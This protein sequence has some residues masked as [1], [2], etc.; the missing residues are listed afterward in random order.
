MT[1]HL[2]MLHVTV[3]DGERAFLTRDGKLER[4]LAPEAAPRAGDDGDA[5]CADPADGSFH[6]LAPTIRC[7]PG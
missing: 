3:K 4:V 1:W 5:P 2:L 6:D 7:R